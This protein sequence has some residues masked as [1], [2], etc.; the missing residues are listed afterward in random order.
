M[1]GRGYRDSN[2]QR[3]L[4]TARR[5]IPCAREFDYIIINDFI[6]KAVDQ[7][8]SIIVASRC[9]REN[10]LKNLKAVLHNEELME[11]IEGA[12]RSKENPSTTPG[13]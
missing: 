13:G 11:L 5:E 10:I 6:D 1:V 7:L 12:R 9:E 4:S 8:K 3:R 2:T